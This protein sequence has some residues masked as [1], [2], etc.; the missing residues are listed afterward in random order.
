[1]LASV[2]IAAYNEQD[3]LT[4]CLEGLRKQSCPFDFEIL[5]V[6]NGSQDDTGRIAAQLGAQ[7]IVEPRRGIARALQT[8][9][10]A[11]SGEII[12]VTDADTRVPKEWLQKLCETLNSDSAIAAAT[13]PFDF[14][15]SKFMGYLTRFWF[16]FGYHVTAGVADTINRGYFPILV[17]PNYAVRAAVLKKIGGLDTSLRTCVDAYLAAKL[18]TVGRIAFVPNVLVHTSARRFHTHPVRSFV[19]YGVSNYASMALFGRV[20]FNDLPD[21]R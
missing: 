15:D 4:S 9:F 6:D 8:G 14:F 12:A 18:L 3:Y 5:V 20:V 1:M 21:Y 2:V 10:D 16:A 17:G 11:A 7:V 13:G 19:T